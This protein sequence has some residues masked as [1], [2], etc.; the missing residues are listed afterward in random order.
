MSNN[1]NKEPLSPIKAKNKAKNNYWRWPIKVFFLAVALSLLFGIIGEHFMSRTNIVWAIIVVFIFMLISVF[2]D[3]IGV[4][5]VACNEAPFKEMTAK[6][7]KGAK[8]GLYIV[9]NAA[10]IASLCA[11][12]I[13]DV[14]GVLSGAAGATI[15]IFIIADSSILAYQTIIASFISALIAGLT[16]GGKA[17]IKQYATKNSTKIV[18]LMGKVFSWFSKSK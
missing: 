17:V 1:L 11:D 7:I 3:M 10:K 6:K 16:I 9:K 5:V 2:T 13:G 4:A 15:L 8:Q 14:C 12:V 18:L